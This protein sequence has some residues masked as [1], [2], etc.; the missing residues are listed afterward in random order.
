MF[1]VRET[2]EVGLVADQIRAASRLPQDVFTRATVV[3][4]LF[5]GVA[6]TATRDGVER[7]CMGESPGGLT[8]S[9]R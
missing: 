3:R 2:R 6:G 5:N 1:A 9:R 7:E 8:V 4:V